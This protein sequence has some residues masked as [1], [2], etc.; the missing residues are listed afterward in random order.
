MSNMFILVFRVK[1]D[2][3]PNVRLYNHYDWA[4]MQADCDMIND[5]TEYEAYF[6]TSF[7]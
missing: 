3:F 5:N 6:D 1:G 7:Q 4:E 2:L